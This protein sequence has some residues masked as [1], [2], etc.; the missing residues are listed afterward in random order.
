MVS[1]RQKVCCAIPIAFLCMVTPALLRADFHWGVTVFRARFVPYA[2]GG[3][4]FSEGKE[5]PPGHPDSD[6]EWN[7]VDRFAFEGRI[8]DLGEFPFFEVREAPPGDYP[9]DEVT[10]ILYHVYVL[11][12]KEDCYVKLLVICNQPHY[13]I[14]WVYQ[15]D[16]TRNLDWQGTTTEVSQELVTI[17]QKPKPPMLGQNYPNPFNSET[18]IPLALPDNG[19]HQVKLVVFNSLGQRVSNLLD[20]RLLGGIHK[21]KWDGKD[22]SGVEV[23]SGIYFIHAYIDC[24]YSLSRRILLIK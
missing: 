2:A 12:T 5:L 10:I 17:L 4:D 22:R 14:L 7:L 21:I 23:P 15:D 19:F 24:K 13:A 20:A 6:L 11:K 16:G 18:T 9:E 3:V 1:I 8:L